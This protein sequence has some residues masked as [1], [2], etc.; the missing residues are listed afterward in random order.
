MKRINY[1]LLFLSCIFLVSGCK[2]SEPLTNAVYI[3]EASGEN[4]SRLTIDEQGG[5]FKINVRSGNLVSA[6]TRVSIAVDT[7]LLASFNKLNGTDYAPLPDSFYSLS[8]N[9]AV[10]KAGEMSG[11]PVN[12]SIKPLDSSL[13]NTKT[14][15]V[16]VTLTG[17]SGG[18]T[19]FLAASKTVFVLLDRVIVTPV[20]KLQSNNIEAK[21]KTPL[22]GLKQWT[23]QFSVK[24]DRLSVN[25][26]ALIYAGPDEVYSRFGDVVIKPNQLQVKTGNGQLASSTQ[27]SENTW[28]HFALVYDGASLKVFVNGEQDLNVAAPTLNK[29]YRFENVGFGNSTFSGML[30]EIRLWS[31]ALTPSQIKNN[32]YVVDP[33]SP[34]LEV[35]WPANEGQ[36]S[37]LQDITGHGNTIDLSGKGIQWVQGVRFPE[38]K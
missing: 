29:L 26:Q 28:Y 13:P 32:L 11:D 36:G 1:I 9:S 38:R 2:K 7:S 17:I 37:I 8:S 12:L 21:L 33:K 22:E 3:S 18:E 10:I 14:Y 31:V 4:A 24:T 15:V 25:N 19:S 5:A 20:L 23:F 27:F 30:R 16:P 34:N 35:Y 6:E